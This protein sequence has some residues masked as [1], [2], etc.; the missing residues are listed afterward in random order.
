MCLDRTGRAVTA[1]QVFR[2][3]ASS[4]P[5]RMNSPTGVMPSDQCASSAQTADA[6]N[7]SN[8]A[9][10]M[11]PQRT[12]V[13]Q[14]SS[15][16]NPQNFSGNPNPD[17]DPSSNPDSNSSPHQTNQPTVAYQP[18]HRRAQN[19]SG[20]P[21]ALLLPKLRTER[22][23]RTP[24]AEPARRG[25]IRS[26]QTRCLTRLLLTRLQSCRRSS[27]TSSAPG[28]TPASDRG[29]PGLLN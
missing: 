8:D 19:L 3:S 23:R 10:Q 20:S 11:E 17:P 18:P 28:N 21:P 9:T 12:S 4:E 7:L 15:A 1:L 6:A 14:E 25:L 26:T 24:I 5:D 13:P 16:A 2:V 29:F 22:S 27:N